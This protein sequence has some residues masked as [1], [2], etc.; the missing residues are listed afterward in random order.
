VDFKVLGRCTKK[1]VLKQTVYAKSQLGITARLH[2]RI[3]IHAPRRH[4]LRMPTKEKRAAVAVPQTKRARTCRGCSDSSMSAEGALPDTDKTQDEDDLF[5][6]TTVE[7][8]EDG[9]GSVRETK[10][11]FYTFEEVMCAYKQGKCV[12]FPIRYSL[13]E[14]HKM[15]AA[16]GQKPNLTAISTRECKALDKW[17]RDNE[18]HGVACATPHG[19]QFKNQARD[20]RVTYSSIVCE[21]V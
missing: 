14:R 5:I 21:M 17:T 8:V 12:Q 13:F 11:R 18:I 15:F 16:L 2:K 10:E 1:R 20:R 9:S 6:M 7:F 4:E 3:Q 19:H